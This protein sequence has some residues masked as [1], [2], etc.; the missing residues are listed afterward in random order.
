MNTIGEV[1]L[2]YENKRDKWMEKDK[3]ST[4]YLHV[5]I[6]GLKKAGRPQQQL[7]FQR[8]RTGISAGKKRKSKTTSRARV[9]DWGKTCQRVMSFLLLCSVDGA[10]LLACDYAAMTWVTNTV[11]SAGL[12][13]CF[14]DDTDISFGFLAYNRRKSETKEPSCVCFWLLWQSGCVHPETPRW[15][16]SDFTSAVFKSRE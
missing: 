7:I 5:Q 8:G 16:S 14:Y 2:G 3:T 13:S 12:H 6:Y 1:W 11:R 10:A 9:T 4:T 15:R